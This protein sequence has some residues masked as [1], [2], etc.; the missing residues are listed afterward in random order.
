MKTAESLV[1]QFTFVAYAG[2]L[3]RRDAERGQSEAIGRNIFEM[4]QLEIV[5]I[6]HHHHRRGRLWR[7][8][9]A[10][11]VA[12]QVVMLRYSIYSVISPEGCASI[13][14]RKPL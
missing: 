7:C 8:F 4:A 10:I 12:D 5:P 2:R 1:C 3:P 13:L 11:S 6:I 14:W 9:L